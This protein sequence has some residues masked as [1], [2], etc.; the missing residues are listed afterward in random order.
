MRK[1]S[2]TVLV[3][4]TLALVL[5]G[6]GADGSEVAE[7]STTGSTTTTGQEDPKATCS[8]ARLSEDVPEP[9]GLPAPVAMMRKEILKAGVRCDYELLERLAL[10]GDGTFQYSFGQDGPQ[11]A[12][13]HW[14]ALEADEEEVLAALVEL[15]GLPY[16]TDAVMP[17]EGKGATRIY[18]WPSAHQE[19]PT[20]ADWKALEAIYAPAEIAQWRSMGTYLGYRVGI[21]EDG[22][23]IYFV[24]GD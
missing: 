1:T 6:C 20:E 23:W 19:N 16:A 14:R 2:G 13:E 8:A 10:G 17:E 7:P 11:G 21:S 18:S 5:G 4:A 22:D 24:A 3:L 15:V 12:A 9:E